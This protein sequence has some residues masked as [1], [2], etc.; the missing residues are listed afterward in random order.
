MKTVQVVISLVAAAV[1][2]C[3]GCGSS[4]ASH[5]SVQ[6]ARAAA[7]TKVCHDLVK[8]IRW[9]R[10]HSATL[11]LVDA[12]QVGAWLRSDQSRTATGGALWFALRAANR[13][14]SRAL[15]GKS[16][17]GGSRQFASSARS[18]CVALGVT[19]SAP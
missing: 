15:S 14:F 1:L 9:V 7:D 12:M 17:N 16:S 18:A 10:R 13:D 2:A 4:A 11:T 3:A 5:P 6:S 19:P 8:Q